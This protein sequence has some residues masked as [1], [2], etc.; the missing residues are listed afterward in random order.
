[1]LCLHSWLDNDSYCVLNEKMKHKTRRSTAEF[2]RT[3]EQ[4][5][6]ETLATHGCQQRHDS[7]W[8]EAERA[9]LRGC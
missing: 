1:M 5:P 4:D 9:L 6:A 2:V 7:I 8:G 3:W